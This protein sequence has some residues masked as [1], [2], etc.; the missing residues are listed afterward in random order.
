MDL[1]ERIAGWIVLA[2]MSQ[3]AA[4]DPVTDFFSNLGNPK[5]ALTIQHPAGVQIKV[6]TVAIAKPEG[7]CS[8]DLASRVEEDFVGAG[9]T[10]IDRQRFEDI[11]NEHKLQVSALFEQKTAAKVGALLGAQ[12]LLFI[13]VLDCHGGKS[14]Q[15]LGTDKKGHTSYNY[16]V[17]GSVAGSVR[18][19]SL[20]TGQVLASQRFEGTGQAQ[21]YEG[22]PDP[23]LAMESA[24]KTAAFSVHKLLLPW[25]ETKRIV[26]YNDTQCDL[27]LA[28][29]ML[30]SQDLDGAL[31][32][33]QKNLSGCP[34]SP[35]VKPA[36]IAHAYYNLGVLQ[37]MS[38]DFDTALVNLGK[39][40]ELDSSKI[41][42][43]A[44]ADCKRAKQ[45]AV[46]LKESPGDL[47]A[48]TGADVVKPAPNGGGKSVPKPVKVKDAGAGDGKRAAPGA[49][50]ASDRLANLE[51]LLKKKLI[52]QDEYNAKRAQILSGI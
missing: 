46:A 49:A 1:T 51:D 42:T 6:T 11:L 40:T 24:E 44:I 35:K 29:N 4:A 50:S 39:A 8:E 31:K 38:D 45:L 37:F 25:Q 13:K 5:F 47:H 3:A 32:Q 36:N 28:S 34:G 27:K 7:Q 14:Q 10:V 23:A 18:V 17:T 43:D 16:V 48:D 2:L 22:F 19:V 41:Y 33:S 15:T 30:K 12:A 9:V 52:T 21:N 20:T 26:F